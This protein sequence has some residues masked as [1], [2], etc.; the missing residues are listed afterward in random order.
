MGCGVVLGDAW[1]GPLADGLEY[2][3]G[4]IA[5]QELLKSSSGAA[6]LFAIDAGQSV[7]ETSQ[8][9]D[10]MIHVLEGALTVTVDG[11]PHA[12]AAGSAV[13]IPAHRPHGLSAD[14]RTKMVLVM[15]RAA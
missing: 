11:K 10:A 1:S 15:L 8:P 6:T 7:G 5:S 2:R 14:E 9:F 3:D 12:A 13:L 4:A